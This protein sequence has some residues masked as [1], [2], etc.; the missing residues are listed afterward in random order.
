VLSIV[1][2]ALNL[3]QTALMTVL[4]DVPRTARERARAEITG[5]ILATARQHL[6]RDGAAALSLRAIAR[7]LGMVS[8]AVYR[9]VPNRDALLTMLIIDAYDT[10]GAQVEEAAAACPPTDYLGRFL[11]TCGA[12]R[13]WALA[14]PH[15]YALIYGSPVPGYAAPEDTIAPATRVPAVLISILFD[16]TAAGVAPTAVALEPTVSASIA[17]LR[18]FAGGQVS[19]DLLLRGLAS[20]GTLLGTVSLELFGHLHNVVAE[21]GDERAAFFDHQMR[22]VAD[23]LGLAAD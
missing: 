11:A 19:D 15:E 4:P 12:L 9:Y 10:V 22:Q 23:G 8:S 18:E 21:G 7:D 3:R 6:A 1:A 13:T 17:P 2:T 20:W 14:N 16:Q 5:E